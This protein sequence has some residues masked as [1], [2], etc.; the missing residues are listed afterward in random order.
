MNRRDQNAL[1]FKRL[2]AQSPPANAGRLM[3]PALTA[4]RLA[5]TINC[6][7]RTL[8][9]RVKTDALVTLRSRFPD[10]VALQRDDKPPHMI[11]VAVTAAR[12]GLHAPT[13]KFTGME[14]LR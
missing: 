13:Q 11:V 5:K 7:A 12:T 2:L 14:G 6:R 8:A 9:Y 4:N 1:T 10:H 3:H